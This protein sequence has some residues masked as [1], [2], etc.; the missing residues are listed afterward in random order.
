MRAHAVKCSES[1][2][3]IDQEFDTDKDVPIIMMGDFNIDAKRNEDAF[4]FLKHHLNLNMVPANYPSAF[5]YSPCSHNPIN[6][7]DKRAPTNMF[8]HPQKQNV[9]QK[10]SPDT[11]HPLPG[12][13]VPHPH[14]V[15]TDRGAEGRLHLGSPHRQHHRSGPR[16]SPAQ[17]E[18]APVPPAPAPSQRQPPAPHVPALAS[19]SSSTVSH[20]AAH[21]RHPLP[22]PPAAPAAAL[23][24]G[25]LA[26]AHA[27]ARGA[28]LCAHGHSPR[29]F[30]IWVKLNDIYTIFCTECGVLVVITAHGPTPPDGGNAI[31]GTHSRSE[32]PLTNP[33][34]LIYEIVV[35]RGG[36]H[37]NSNHKWSRPDLPMHTGASQ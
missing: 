35:P 8:L 21:P 14:R 24:P 23:L 2:L 17:G 32:N 25:H 28:N 20:D 10:S 1:S 30:C 36:S 11:H 12:S 33:S 7:L 22:A 6:P 19:P 29:A 5:G 3:L 9:E 31:T 34:V 26:H 37:Y 13:S 27:A 4:D 15:L 18:A 16:G